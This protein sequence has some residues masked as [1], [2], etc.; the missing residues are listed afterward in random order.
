MQQVFLQKLLMKLQV[1]NGKLSRKSI[2]VLIVSLLLL[3]I[4]FMFLTLIN[5]KCI[6]H[7]MGIWCAGCGGT[8]MIISFFKLDFYQSFRW[9]PLLFILLIVGILY[10][11]VGV[12]I[13]FRKK[14]ILIP[15]LK[16][17][18]FLIIL[19]I[20]YMI[21]RNIDMFSYLI[22]TRIS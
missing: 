21:L 8:R 11:I 13:Y 5:Y 14:M 22:P 2:I 16:V 15:T 12:V 18:I 3:L 1:F 20:I 6:F 7:E 17:W 4:Y 9:N 10:F 19:L